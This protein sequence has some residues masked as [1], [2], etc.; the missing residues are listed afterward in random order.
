MPPAGSMKDLSTDRN[1][2]CKKQPQLA[3]CQDPFMTRSRP[4]RRI[5]P[6][7]RRS[8]IPNDCFYFFSP[9]RISIIFRKIPCWFRPATTAVAP[10]GNEFS[11]GCDFADH[12]PG[13]AANFIK[14]KETRSSPIGR[15]F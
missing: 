8:A 13:N 10:S 3:K 12:H 7:N 4:D 6:D 15:K 9:S 1:L 11:A 2:H 5:T 14:T